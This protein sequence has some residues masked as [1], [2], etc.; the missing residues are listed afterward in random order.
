[1]ISL[2]KQKNEWKIKEYILISNTE[3]LEEAGYCFKKD[4]EK[5]KD[6][7]KNVCIVECWL[8][9]MGKNMVNYIQIVK[10]VLCFGYRVRG[11]L[12]LGFSR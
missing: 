11:L 12:S 10:I 3:K 8:M 1:M 6:L 9:G 7:V 5:T 4:Y 2:I